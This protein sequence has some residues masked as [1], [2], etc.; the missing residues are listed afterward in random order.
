[1]QSELL[2]SLNQLRQLLVPPFDI[3]QVEIKSSNWV[4][5]AF[6]ENIPKWMNGVWRL[7]LDSK[8]KVPSLDDTCK[9]IAWDWVDKRK[10]WAN[11]FDC[12]NFS[13]A[14]KVNANM[15]FKLNHIGIVLDYSGAHGYNL[16]LT[17]D[18]RVF[19]YEPQTDEYWDIREHDYRNPYKLQNA[20]ILV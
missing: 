4:N 17:P 20:Y 15:I 16:F 9:I 7:P 2:S 8:Y 11:W 6:Q 5:L 10:Y 13:L 19:L 14:F 18:G 12:E 1:M 3:E